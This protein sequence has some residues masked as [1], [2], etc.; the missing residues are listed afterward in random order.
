MKCLYVKLTT[1]VYSLFFINQLYATTLIETSKKSVVKTNVSAG[2]VLQW[3]YERDESKYTDNTSSSNV[4]RARLFIK[5]H[6]NN[7]A[8]KTT[9]K[10][11]ENSKTNGDAVEAYV[12]YTGFGNL[13][14][15]TVGKQKEPFSLEFLTSSKDISLLER[16]AITEYYAYGP[17]LG[18]QLHGKR[19]NW[20][21][22]LGIFESNNVNS[23][24]FHN[25]TLTGRMTKALRFSNDALIHLG[26]GFTSRK[27][28]VSNKDITN[29]NLEFSVV[30]NAFHLQSEYFHSTISPMFST[31]QGHYIQAGYIFNGTRPYKNGIFKSVKPHGEQGAW[32]F[33]ARS[34]RG[35]GKFSDI[36]LGKKE[37]K[38]TSIG[39]NYYLNNHIRMGVSYMIGKSNVTSNENEELRTRL[40]FYF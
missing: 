24:S 17:T 12:R 4:R 15:V 32:E 10:L 37:G 13:F 21:Y 34:E 30:H 33:V 28:P 23:D 19:N 38:Q 27:H 29:Y 40:Q 2:G 8:Y 1:L 26:A 20:T 36:N 9:F 14:N 16:S 3:D 31:D 18:V 11:G 5:G 7:W 35:L 39:V 22:G 6:F 25:R